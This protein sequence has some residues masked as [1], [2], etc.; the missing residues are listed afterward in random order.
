MDRLTTYKSQEANQGIDSSKK[1][2]LQL[3][4]ILNE[5]DNMV[6]KIY[7]LSCSLKKDD[8]IPLKEKISN[9]SLYTTELEKRYREIGYKIPEIK[10]VESYKEIGNHISRLFQ[11]YDSF[12]NFK[13]I[14]VASSIELA[15]AGLITGV[16]SP[17]FG[18][19]YATILAPIVY[20]INSYTHERKHRK[21]F[22][23]TA[24]NI[25]KIKDIFLEEVRNLSK[26][27]KLAT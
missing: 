20:T 27:N 7:E 6:K 9:S 25:Y 10:S 19:V 14:V 13:K 21:E 12:Y 23:S 18:L 4:E 3:P 8:S 24:A 1:E 15:A 22:I 11:I 17:L 2:Y 16:I 5:F 26:L